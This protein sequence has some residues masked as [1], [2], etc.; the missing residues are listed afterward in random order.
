MDGSLTYPH[1]LSNSLFL[2][3]RK[4]RVRQNVSASGTLQFSHKLLLYK[5]N[6]LPILV[7]INQNL[8]LENREISKW[9]CPNIGVLVDIASTRV[10]T[11]FLLCIFFFWK[12]AYIKISFCNW[13]SNVLIFLRSQLN[14][15]YG[16]V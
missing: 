8:N 1:I 11:F 4:V 9:W 2:K 7:F 12:H 14:L 10:S 3:K 15:S 5:K 16:Y 13:F 6:F